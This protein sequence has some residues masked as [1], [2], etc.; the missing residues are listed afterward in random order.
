MKQIFDVPPIPLES[1]GIVSNDGDSTA[2]QF[3][4][5]TV[6]IICEVDN[7]ATEVRTDRKLIIEDSI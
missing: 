7:N 2:N 3:N 4:S 5:P 1:Q 6:K